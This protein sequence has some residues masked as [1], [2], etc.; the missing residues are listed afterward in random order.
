MRPL[1]G[2][3]VVLSHLVTRAHAYAGRQYPAR[4]WAAC[5]QGQVA[6]ERLHGCHGEHSHWVSSVCA[7]PAAAASSR[8]SRRRVTMNL[9]ACLLSYWTKLSFIKRAHVH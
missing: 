9:A 1:S 7:M 8:L 6:A 4:E 2:I 3:S 5:V